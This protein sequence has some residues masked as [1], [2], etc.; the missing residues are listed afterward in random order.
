MKLKKKRKKHPI[1][2]LFIA[3]GCGALVAY[4]GT[5]INESAKRY[6]LK[7]RVYDS[8]L[9]RLEKIVQEQPL[10]QPTQ[11]YHEFSIIEKSTNEILGTCRIYM[12][13]EA[14]SYYDGH[15]QVTLCNQNKANCLPAIYTML[16]QVAKE[17]LM[18]HVY[19]V[20]DKK[21]KN[22][23]R[24]FEMLNAKFN[25]FIEIPETHP[26]YNKRRKIRKQYKL[27]LN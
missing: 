11:L 4:I 13:Q 25:K 22:S 19:L 9:Y 1:R 10:D 20:C 26:T 8:D 21:D 2:N 23:V 18:N 24:L 27:E 17:R 5:Q 3:S 7:K 6:E 14:T 15:I 12:G 16:I